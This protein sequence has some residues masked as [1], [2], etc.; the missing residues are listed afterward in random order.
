MYKISPRVNQTLKIAKAWLKFNPNQ[1]NKRVNKK[2]L[3]IT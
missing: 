3:V 2:N 1:V